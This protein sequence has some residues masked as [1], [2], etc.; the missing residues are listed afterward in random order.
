MR[1]LIAFSSSSE[2]FNPHQLCSEQE[3]LGLVAALVALLDDD[4]VPEP[5]G[6]GKLSMAAGLS[7]TMQA[8]VATVIAEAAPAVTIA[9]GTLSSAAIRSPTFSCSSGI[10]T[11][12]PAASFIAWSTSGGMSDPPRVV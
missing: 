2:R 6:L 11:N 8:A 5:G 12:Q 9:A 1:G 3:H 7:R 4:L 10:E